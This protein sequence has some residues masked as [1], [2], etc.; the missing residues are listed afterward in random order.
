ML[1]F[2]Y[3]VLGYATL[4]IWVI[5]TCSMI[6]WV[7]NGQVKDKFK[8]IKEDDGRKK[9]YEKILKI[10]NYVLCFLIFTMVVSSLDII[11]MTIGVFSPIRL[12]YKGI[13]LASDVSGYL[14]ILFFRYMFKSALNYAD[15]C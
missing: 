4:V 13:I 1:Y 7:F 14:L 11:L 6:Y 10:I 15:S 9:K 5:L 2:S 12:P 3:Q 8:N